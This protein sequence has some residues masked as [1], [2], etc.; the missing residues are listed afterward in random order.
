[1]P[2]AAAATPA[3]VSWST[4]ASLGVPRGAPFTWYG[5]DRDLRHF[6]EPV[7]EHRVDVGSAEDHRSLAQID[8]TVL[9]LVDGRAVG[10]VGDV[11]ADSHLGIDAERRG[12]GAAQAD[13]LL[14]RRHHEERRVEGLAGSRLSASSTTK[15][16]AVLS[17][18][19]PV[20]PVV[21]QLARAEID[22]HRV[23]DPH[24]ALDLLGRRSRRGRPT[25]R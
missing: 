6:A 8:R 3:R 23:A 10:G 19:G 15:R 2:I 20:S 12:G 17:S 9:A 1:M 14:H 4:L 13:L 22:R 25:G 16:P 11:D 5:S 21:R 7:V 18:L 24:R